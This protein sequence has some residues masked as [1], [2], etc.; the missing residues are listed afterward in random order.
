MPSRLRRFRRARWALAVVIAIGGVAAHVRWQHRADGSQYLTSAVTRGPV[1]RTL[2]TTGAVD[3][4]I[5]VE[6]GAYVSGTL[7]SC[8][9]DYTTQVKAGQ[10][11]AKMDPRPYQV[12]VDQDTANLANARAQLVKDQAGLAA[13]LDG[14][15]ARDT[16][17]SC[18]S[19]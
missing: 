19:L 5:T 16:V 4:V 6:V 9:C 3:P 15:G 10:L 12:V 7:E 14:A 18:G 17:K 11:C 1:V 13:V 8:S 2:T